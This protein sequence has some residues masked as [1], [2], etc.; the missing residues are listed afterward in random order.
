MKEC[1]SGTGI[2][3]PHR[4]LKDGYDVGLKLVYPAHYFQVVVEI[5]CKHDHGIPNLSQFC[6]FSRCQAKPPIPFLHYSGVS[7]R[8]E[9]CAM[10]L[11]PADGLTF[12]HRP[13]RTIYYFNMG[14]ILSNMIGTFICS[15]PNCKLY[16]AF[17]CSCF[18]FSVCISLFLFQCH[19]KFIW[20]VRNYAEVFQIVIKLWS[21]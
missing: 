21:D 12:C 6:R 14:E 13:T 3:I 9:G 20:A 11:T 8:F 16:G 1:K 4:L 10:V 17:T 19:F 18:A 15:T 2:C 7:P 5:L